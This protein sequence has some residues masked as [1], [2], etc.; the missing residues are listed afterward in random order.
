MSTKNEDE[1]E[2]EAVAWIGSDTGGGMFGRGR[3]CQQNL[4]DILDETE[5]NAMRSSSEKGGQNQRN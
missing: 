2:N 1:R 4:G 5:A 3:L